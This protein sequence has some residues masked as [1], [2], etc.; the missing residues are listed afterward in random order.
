LDKISKALKVEIEDF[1][2]WSHQG[3]SR[4]EIDK[5]ITALLQEASPDIL[6]II[7]K[8]VRAIIR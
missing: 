5:T 6:P 2:E 8:V 7:V 4:R 1:F 3:K